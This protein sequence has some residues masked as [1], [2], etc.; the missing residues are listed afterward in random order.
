MFSSYIR[1][2]L[3]IILTV[4]YRFILYIIYFYTCLYWWQQLAGW[5]YKQVK[6]IPFLPSIALI[7]VIY[8]LFQAS[9]LENI[10]K[11]LYSVKNRLDIYFLI[12]GAESK[13]RF[14]NRQPTATGRRRSRRTFRCRWRYWC[15]CSQH[16]GLLCWC[17]RSWA[18]SFVTGIY[19][20]FQIV[21]SHLL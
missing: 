2:C 20:I 7:H 17:W 16:T 15:C 12:V 1:V 9:S 18:W 10:K 3:V 14:F 6:Y 19:L 5:E 21:N 4:Y 8:Y 11:K 13:I